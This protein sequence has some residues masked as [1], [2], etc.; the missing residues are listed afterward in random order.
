MY[1]NESFVNYLP[2]GILYILLFLRLLNFAGYFGL[3]YRLLRGWNK[4]KFC[5][6]TVSTWQKFL[7]DFYGILSSRVFT[8]SWRFLTLGNF[9]SVFTHPVDCFC[10]MTS[11]YDTVFDMLYF[12]LGYSKGI[13]R[14]CNGLSLWC[15]VPGI[16]NCFLYVCLSLFCNTN[17]FTL[18]TDWC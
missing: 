7:L 18:I 12:Q 1:I 4:Y 16:N 2:H 10:P 9:G 6:R 11:F 5:L 14:L 15:L 13:S 17:T 8:V 3:N